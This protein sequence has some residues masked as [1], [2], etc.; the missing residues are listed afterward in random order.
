MMAVFRAKIDFRF[1]GDKK[2]ST[3]L[4][5]QTFESTIDVSSQRL[6]DI[7]WNPPRKYLQ[8]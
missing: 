4:W 6:L 7:H 5:Y 1:F 3:K 2:S 8:N